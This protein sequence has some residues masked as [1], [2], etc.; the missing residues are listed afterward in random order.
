MLHQAEACFIA[1]FRR[2]KV[3]KN[4]LSRASIEIPS[5]RLLFVQMV[6][7]QIKLPAQETRHAAEEKPYPAQKE[8]SFSDLNATK[9]VFKSSQECRT[10]ENP[11]YHHCTCNRVTRAFGILIECPQMFLRRRLV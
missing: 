7:I 11:V 6:R 2:S 1:C 4:S 10:I 5:Q 9:Y 3:L 8:T